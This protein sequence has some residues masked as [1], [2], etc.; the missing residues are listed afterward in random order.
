[1]MARR[2]FALLVAVVCIVTRIGVEASGPS[3]SADE[4]RALTDQDL[5]CRMSSDADPVPKPL[6]ESV[7][8]ALPLHVPGSSACLASRGSGWAVKMAPA[9]RERR[10]DP[11]ASRGPPSS[12]VA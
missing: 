12:V 3:A 2:F 5:V 6:E 1:M 10:G 11:R 4:V 7:E 9:A 8:L